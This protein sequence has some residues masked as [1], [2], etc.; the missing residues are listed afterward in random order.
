MTIRI[1]HADD[2]QT[3]RKA[4][5]HFLDELPGVTCVGQAQDGPEAL[6]KAEELQPDLVLLDI[7]MPTMNGMEVARVIQSWEQPPYIVFLSLHDSNAYQ[8]CAHAL[9][10]LAFI[11]KSDFVA[12]LRPLIA[13]LGLV[14]GLKQPQ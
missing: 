7:A 11:G 10:A 2:N 4:V 12:E 1:L 9:G 14:E 13:R 8:A 5:K 6:A 3:F